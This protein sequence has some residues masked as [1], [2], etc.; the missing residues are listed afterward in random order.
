MVRSTN[1]VALAVSVLALGWS[2]SA[3]AQ[4]DAKKAQEVMNKAG[5]IACHQ[6]DRKG[7]GPA[8]KD[9]AKKHKG[10]ANAPA[11]LFAKARN[12]G[13]GVWGPIPMP[14]NPPA[15]IS[16]GELKQLIGWILAL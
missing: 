16:D 2:A 6:I 11:A 4:M 1:A 7:V 5:C 3:A 15:K 12:G 8:Y 14:P 9:V 10:D 13:A